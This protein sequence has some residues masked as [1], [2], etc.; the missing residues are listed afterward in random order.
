MRISLAS[1]LFLFLPTGSAVAAA[2]SD[3]HLESVKEIFAWVNGAKD[4]FVTS[5]QSVRRMV[6][7]DTSTPLMV[8]A[9]ED[10]QEGELLVQTPWSHI[11]RSKTPAA[12]DHYGWHCGTAY[13]LKEEI[14]KGKDSFY[15]PYTTYVNDEPEGQLPSRYSTKAKKLLEQVIG[16]HPDEVNRSPLFN[17]DDASDQRLSPEA[18]L[19]T[20]DT[21]FYESCRPKRS[22][23]LADKAAELLMLRGDDH[24]M[25]PAYDAYNH[26]NNDKHN[27]KVYMNAMTE[28]TPGEHHQTFAKR[29]IQKGEQIFISYNM[30]DQ[31]QARSHS[32]FGTAEMFRE[33]GFVEWFP[34]RWC[35]RRCDFLVVVCNCRLVGWYLTLFLC[36]A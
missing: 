29:D 1:L 11:I 23:K 17:R 13:K 27:G 20:M 28:T 18:L 25:I 32:G 16:S 31:C 3:P 30:C 10:I 21:N 2:T 34:Q 19:S 22:D 36:R 14:L 15:A 4:G 12:D 8:Y 24:I 9:T 6:E 35:V 26:R 5:K 7:N 33:Y